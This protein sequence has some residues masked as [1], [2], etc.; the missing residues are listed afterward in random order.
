MITLSLR[1]DKN[2]DEYRT[3]SILHTFIERY[4]CKTYAVQS[5]IT[6]FGQRT[7]SRKLVYGI[8]FCY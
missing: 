2:L 3:N 1:L 4:P 8:R 5:K 6:H 7:Q